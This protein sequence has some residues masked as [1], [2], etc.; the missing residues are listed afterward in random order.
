LDAPRLVADAR[1]RARLPGL[2]PAPSR[3]A[4]G[5]S[6]FRDYDTAAAILD[7][8]FEAGCNTLDTAWIYGVVRGDAP[9]ETI[10]GRWI[11]AR[12]VEGDVVV[13][14]KAAHP[15]E[16]RPESV[17]AQVEESLDRLGLARLHMVQVHRDDTSIPVGEW[18]EALIALVDRGYAASYGV[19]NWTI[20]RLQALYEY[21]DARQRLRPA[22]VSDQL[23]L[24][25]MVTP[26][27][28][29]CVS[30]RSQDERRWL[31]ETDTLLIPWAS[32][33]RGVFTVDEAELASGW[34]SESWYSPANVRRINRA[35]ELA[36]SRGVEPINVA[37]AW[38][39]HQP[40]P[41]LPVIGPQSPAEIASSLAALDLRLEQEEMEWLDLG[42]GQ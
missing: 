27:Y 6:G 33:G 11:R 1:V 5:T 23:S 18:A 13:F 26:I 17:A 42:D 25:E 9:V 2:T 20:E 34:L 32:Q 40:F 38:V 4:L 21:A 28:E 10:V 29:G 36:R 15:P 37:L 41:C 16:C 7:A 35:K 12:G 39:L 19:S 22:G 30:L 31:T 3:L 8:W 14:G 24:A